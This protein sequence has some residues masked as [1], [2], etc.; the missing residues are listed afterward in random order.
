VVKKYLIILAY[1][2]LAILFWYFFLNVNRI[3]LTTNKITYETDYNIELE[4]FNKSL[5]TIKI[6]EN[7][8]EENLSIL[9]KVPKGWL[10]HGADIFTCTNSTLDSKESEDFK[11]LY[12]FQKEI[13]IVSLNDNKYVSGKYYF[14]M[15]VQVN[16]DLKHMFSFYSHNIFSNT[17]DLVR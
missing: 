17:F 10:K 9:I 16:S 15:N 2:V 7:C 13:I 5:Y 3:T 1:I 12:P 6:P 11:N 8:P 14:D 4:L